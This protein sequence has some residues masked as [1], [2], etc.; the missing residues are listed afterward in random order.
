[1]AAA[2]S[3]VFVVDHDEHSRKSIGTVV[4]SAGMR[5]LPFSSAEDFLDAFDPSQPGCL[6]T[7][8]R[9]PYLSGLELQRRMTDAE[10]AL[11]VIVVSAHASIS[12]AVKAMKQGAVTFLQKPFDDHELYEAI[13]EALARDRENRKRAQQRQQL[14]NRIESLSPEERQVMDSVVA[15]ASNKAIAESLDIGLRTV[16]LRKRRVLEKMQAD[17]IPSLV[18]LAMEAGIAG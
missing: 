6:I 18:R 4:R 8:V 5:S 10:H 17:G 12:A 11:P 16:E 14:R 3:V 9:L 2:E 7:A 15:G 13:C 1:M